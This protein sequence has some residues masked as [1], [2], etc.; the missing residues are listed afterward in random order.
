MTGHH[1]PL[2]A[3]HLARQSRF[4]LASH[5]PVPQWLGHPLRVVRVQAQLL[6]NLGIGQIQPH[7]DK[8]K[9]HTRKG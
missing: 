7:E 1:G 9:P 2:I 3:F 6:G 8:N 4:R 5:D